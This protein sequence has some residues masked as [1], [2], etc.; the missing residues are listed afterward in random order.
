MKEKERELA[1]QAQLGQQNHN[2]EVSSILLAQPYQS[3]NVGLVS[4][5]ARLYLCIDQLKLEKLQMSSAFC[6]NKFSYDAL[7]KSYVLR[8]RL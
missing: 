2:L 4:I 6:S 1:E 5:Y 7:H 8:D 3:L